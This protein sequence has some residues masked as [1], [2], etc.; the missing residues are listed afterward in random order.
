MSLVLDSSVLVAALVDTGIAGAWAEEVMASGPLS[1]P[2]LVYVEATNILRRLERARLLTTHEAN[3]AQ[4]D[5]ML[6]NL[7]LFPFEP[8][9]ERVW[10]LRHGLTSY[11]AWSVAVAEALDLPLA[12]LD[13]RLSRAKGPT[14]DFLTPARR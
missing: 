6:L 13:R 3:A 8:F 7:E 12:T 2:E 1:A 9:S 4:D 14:C 10:Q 5:L 11:D